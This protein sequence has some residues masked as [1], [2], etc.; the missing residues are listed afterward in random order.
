MSR[1]SPLVSME[2]QGPDAGD[3]KDITGEC[4]R[5]ILKHK[6]LVTTSSVAAGTTFP[7]FSH[8]LPYFR[9]RAAKVMDPRSSNK[10][11]CLSEPDLNSEYQCE[12]LDDDMNEDNEH[13]DEDY[14]FE[15]DIGSPATSDEENNCDYDQDSIMN[16][17]DDATETR[18][19]K[20]TYSMSSDTSSSNCSHR[21]ESGV[22]VDGFASLFGSTSS[23]VG[24][25]R[26]SLMQS[27]H[28]DDDVE[29]LS[30]NPDEWKENS[31]LYLGAKLSSLSLSGAR[32][33]SEGSA[34]PILAA[35]P[36]VTSESP[37]VSPDSVISDDLMIGDSLNTE[38]CQECVAASQTSE[39]EENISSAESIIN[40]ESGHDNIR[41]K[42]EN[43]ENES[44]EEHE[45]N[46]PA[47][48]DDIM[49]KLNERLSSP[50]KSV[51]KV[52]INPS[53]V[54]ST[55]KLCNLLHK[56]E[57]DKL[58][59]GGNQ[60]E[61]LEEDDLLMSPLELSRNDSLNERPKLRKC[62]SLKTSKT[63][64]TTPGQ[65][66]IVRLV[67]LMIKFVNQTFLLLQVCRY[68]WSRFVRS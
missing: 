41:N 20:R 68:S 21:K 30:V 66:K 26:R 6:P 17:V 36:M 53:L 67:T 23:G 34:T 40:N 24:S 32:S 5:W 59:S 51:E 63:P 4:S 55:E 29:G 48:S 12:S 3:C 35:S 58:Y 47:K 49:K 31:A 54:V 15:F 37:L 13:G 19:E 18:D 1:M 42:E 46:Q 14:L 65:R 2:S 52:Q 27:E 43:I 45:L 62:S 9:Q 8:H 10:S 16:V 22:V 11:M 56:L 33:S 44:T 60:D 57:S 39:T 64:P 50:T 38:V 25:E 61:A 28:G 7:P